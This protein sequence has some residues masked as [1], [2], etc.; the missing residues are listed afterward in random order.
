M[1]P[2]QIF[3]L[4]NIEY[5]TN[6]L[7]EEAKRLLTLI[8]ESQ[9]ELNRVE[10][11]KTLLEA[12]RQQLIDQLKPLLPDPG[13]MQQTGASGILGQASD[14]IPTTNVEKP[15]QEPSSFP[16]NIPSTIVAKS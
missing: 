9:K 1:D 3:R 16:E 14:R 8:N 2:G 7:N 13:M 10:T 6:H 4:N 15:N 12:A 11:Q 5:N